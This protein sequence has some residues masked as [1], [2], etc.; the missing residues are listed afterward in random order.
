MIFLWGVAHSQRVF[1]SSTRFRPDLNLK[2]KTIESGMEVFVS[3]L[4][5]LIVATFFISC[6]SIRNK[7][8]VELHSPGY[9]HSRQMDER[10]L[11]AG[12]IER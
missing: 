4:L 6:S 3:N 8:P 10:S 11:K 7:T 1:K 5:V 9:Q 2:S 12:F